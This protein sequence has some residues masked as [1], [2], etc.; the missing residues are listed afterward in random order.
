MSTVGRIAPH[1]KYEFQNALPGLLLPYCTML[2]EHHT[3]L[4]NSINTFLR[5]IYNIESWKCVIDGCENNLKWN[6]LIE[7]VIPFTTLAINMP[8][9]IRNRFI[10]SISHLCHQSNLIK[11]SKWID[12]FPLEMDINFGVADKYCSCWKNYNVL[13]RLLENI[14]NKEYQDI[15]KEFRNKYN[16]RYPIRIEI[17]LTEFVKRR[18]GNNGSV[19][20]ALGYTRPLE[21]DQLLPALNAQHK[22]CLD[23]FEQYQKLIHEQSS[24]LEIWGKE[25]I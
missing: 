22:N 18:V 4:S 9:V 10:Y 8:Y 15:T 23:T 20:Y 3:E 11:K 6:I 2:D 16:H 19:H 7:F 25:M 24:Q 5:Y 1:N 12:D 17:G 21:I 14:N 13:K